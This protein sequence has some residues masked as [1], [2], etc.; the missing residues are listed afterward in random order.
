MISTEI[1]KIVLNI[2]IVRICIGDQTLYR[3]FVKNSQS[4]MYT[5]VYFWRGGCSRLS[6][7]SGGELQRLAAARA[8]AGSLQVLILDEPT[9]ALDVITQKTFGRYAAAVERQNGAVNQPR[10]PCYQLLCRYGDNASQSAIGIICKFATEV[11]SIKL[12]SLLYGSL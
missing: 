11:K 1:L 12:A 8:L 4:N 7:F 5:D 9:S 3:V 10:Y 6:L 2:S